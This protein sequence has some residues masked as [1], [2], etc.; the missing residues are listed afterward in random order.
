M[1]SMN[2]NLFV[3][4]F[5]LFLFGGIFSYADE[6]KISEIADVLS[7]TDGV[8]SSHLE[9]EEDAYLEGYI[10]ALVNSHY[11]DF[12]ILVY[13]ENGDVY[14]YNLPVNALTKNSIISFVMDLPEVKSV[15]EVDK[16][17]HKKLEMLEKREVKPSIKGI[18]FP[19]QTVL[20]APMVANPRETLYS[21]VYRWGDKILG[22]NCIAVSLGDSFPIYRWRHVLRWK[23]D[24]QIDI[25]TGIWSVF[26][27]GVHHH[28]GEF[29]ELVNTDYLLGFP[30]S[31]AYD[32]WAYR[33]RLYHVSCHLGDEFI[34]NHHRVKRKNPS[35]EAVDFFI[36]YQVD[37][38]VRLYIGPGVVFHSDDTY[39]INP[40]YVEYGGEVRFLGNKDF[41]NKLYGTVFAAVYFR[42]WQ[43][44]H[45]RLDS[46]WMVGYEWSKLQGVG[47]KMRA[48]VTYHDG[49]SEGQFFK[50]TSKYTGIGFSW[51]F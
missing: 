11:Y 12:D 31:Y 28:E 35:M 8:P 40:L 23:G 41:Y 20:Y 50:L 10:Q 46:T 32:R 27:V 26:K 45:W 49:Y 13:V 30:L 19:Q 16:F 34:V 9:N 22:K 24:L 21:A 25:Q 38:S 5:L 15:T 2:K 4:I 3:N 42:N 47:R 7:R 33:L 6:Y 14:L 39:Y 29:A 17:P 44:N 51:G 36:S 1:L 48:F 43:I 37:D 18:W